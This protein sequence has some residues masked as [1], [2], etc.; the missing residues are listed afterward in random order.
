M[1]P[2]IAP[3]DDWTML[4]IVLA[5]VALSIWLEQRYAWAAKI[6]GPVIALVLAMALSNFGVVASEPL[7]VDTIHGYLVPLAIPLLLFKADVL[8]IVRET[9]TMLV[10]FHVSVLG[11][12]VGTLL[13]T[14]LLGDAFRED[15]EPAHAAGIMAGSYS[16]GGLNFLAVSRSFDA[17]ETMA[18]ALIVSD[19]VIMAGMFLVLLVMAGSKW[20]LRRFPHP[21]TEREVGVDSGTTRAAEHWKPK[22]LGLLDIAKSLAIAW[23]ITAA[24]MHAGPWLSGR[25]ESVTGSGTLGAIAGNPFVL[26]SLGTV[27]LATAFRSWFAN[28]RG[29][30]ELGA[31]L[32]YVFL[33]TIGFPTDVGE[34]LE[35]GGVLFLFCLVIAVT[36]LAVT[37]G[38]GKLLRLDLE[39][40]L[41]C[42]NATLGGPPSAV[43]MA[44]AKGWSEL[45]LPALLVG[46]WGYVIGTFLGVT[47]GQVLLG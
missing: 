31:L 16:G 38:L 7:I 1:N 32:L 17:N 42:V 30:D 44:I 45:V 24:A 8:R 12:V 3:D 40:L 20:M 33:F 28:L 34:M 27:A 15:W 19:N 18:S 13:A 25:V 10:A 36:N 5:G 11:T 22:E 47:L 41:V 29:G 39:E 6:S 2:L 4:G 46:I 23:C 35:T 21:H 26:L 14:W 9:R 37:L 43:A